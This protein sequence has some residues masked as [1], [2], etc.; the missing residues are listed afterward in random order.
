MSRQP[1][2]TQDLSD[3]PGH[4]HGAR[5]ITFW[6]IGAFMLIEGAAF[7]LALT[8][9]FFLMM[10]ETEW[11]SSA[12]PPDLLWGT[13]AA[14]VMVVSVAP[15]IWIQRVAEQERLKDARIGLVIM[16]A[17]GFVLLAIRAMEFS[18]LNVRW[19]RNAYGSIVWA[20]I[21]LHTLHLVTDWID[22]LVLTVLMFTGHGRLGRS[23]VDVEENA[24]YWHFVIVSWV[25][26]YA[27]VYWTPRLT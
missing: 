20:L 9:Y 12:A 17:V 26:I 13:I 18:A 7:A 25:V 22:T 10:Q 19:D 14:A 11:P 3:L 5:S 27:V 24:L 8:A 4:G 16:C 6:G 2:F 23:F 1:T 21:V 15:N